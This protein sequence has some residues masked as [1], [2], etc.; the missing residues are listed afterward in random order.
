MGAGFVDRGDGLDGGRVAPAA[1]AGG[2]TVKPEPVRRR[3]RKRVVLPLVGLV[4]LGVAFE[5]AFV[6][7]RESTVV[8]YNETGAALPALAI[9]AGGVSRVFPALEEEG[10]VRIRLGTAGP[11]GP[12]RLELAKEPPWEWEGGNVE[13]A[14]GQRLSIRLYPDGMVEVDT[15]VSL[16]RRWIGSGEARKDP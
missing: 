14:G 10:S 2:Q 9:R 16:W 3:W 5:V 4:L 11:P 1:R 13:P 6:R 8:V 12:V 7:S 15:Q